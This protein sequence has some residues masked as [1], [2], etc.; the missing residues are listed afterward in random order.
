MPAHGAPAPFDRTVQPA[1]LAEPVVCCAATDSREDNARHRNTCSRMERG[2]RLDNDPS[3]AR[4][5]CFLPDL[6]GLAR[7]SPAPTSQDHHVAPSTCVRKEAK[8]LGNGIIRG[9]NPR[10]PKPFERQSRP[11]R[12]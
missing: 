10:P 11:H 8:G 4:Y 7:R 2:E 1:I 6:T 3:V 9:L 5:G 12:A